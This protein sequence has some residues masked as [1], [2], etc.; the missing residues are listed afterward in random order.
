[1]LSVGIETMETGLRLGS[2]MFCRCH[3]HRYFI[4]EDCKTKDHAGLNFARSYVLSL[5]QGK[6][7]ARTVSRSL[8][9][10]LAYRSTLV[11]VF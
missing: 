8:P 6:N 9:L 10:A 1:M 7:L 2:H 3:R 4:V 11:P 5:A